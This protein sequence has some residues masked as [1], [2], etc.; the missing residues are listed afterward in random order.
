[1]LMYRKSRRVMIAV[2][3]HPVVSDLKR[4]RNYER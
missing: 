4:D 3:K 1:M 2:I